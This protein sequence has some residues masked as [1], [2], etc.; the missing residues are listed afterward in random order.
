MCCLPVLQIPPLPFSLPFFFFYF[1]ACSPTW[2]TPPP[3]LTCSAPVQSQVAA[4]VRSYHPTFTCPQTIHCDFSVFL[5]IHAPIPNLDHVCPFL[6][7]L[8]S[9]VWTKFDSRSGLF[10]LLHSPSVCLPA[11]SSPSNKL[12]MDP[13]YVWSL[14]F[15]YPLYY[16]L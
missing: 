11:C 9:S 8:M 1:S 6:V 12:R 10:C 3:T 4:T 2:P 7:G 15:V 14:G 5:C 13:I 16:L